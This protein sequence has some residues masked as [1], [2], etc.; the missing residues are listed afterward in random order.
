MARRRSAK[1][2]VRAVLDEWTDCDGAIQQHLDDNYRG[3]PEAP[4]LEIAHAALCYF[5]QG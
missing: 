1:S 5:N 4:S 3:R 2:L